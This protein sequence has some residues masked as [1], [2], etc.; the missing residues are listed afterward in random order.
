MK[1][2]LRDQLAAALFAPIEHTYSATC[3]CQA[4]TEKGYNTT[5][6]ETRVWP[7]ERV[8]SKL[9]INNILSNL[10]QFSYNP[11]MKACISCR[12]D[13]TK[14]VREA[15]LTTAN[16]FEGLCIGMSSA[17]CPRFPRSQTIAADPIDRLH[18]TL[19]AKDGARR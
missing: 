14:L 16:Y 15:V 9:V 1:R 3:R 13:Y 2:Y 7:V 12:K 4:E 19:E 10:S 5:L 17:S 6:Y 8:H 11:D 18:G